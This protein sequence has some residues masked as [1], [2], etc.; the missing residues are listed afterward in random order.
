[1]RLKKVTEG[2]RFRSGNLLSLVAALD[3]IL[4]EHGFTINAMI[5]ETSPYVV[6]NG[7]EDRT[8]DANSTTTAELADVLATLLSDLRAKGIIS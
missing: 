6:T 3:P 2:L 7:T 1:M 8:F 4:R 5:G